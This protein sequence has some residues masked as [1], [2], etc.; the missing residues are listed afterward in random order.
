L[1]DY[2]ARFYDPQIGRWMTIDPKAEQY[3]RWSPYNYC[4]DNPIRFID[5]D[6]MGVDQD[7]AQYSYMAENPLGVVLDGFRQ[8]FQAVASLFSFDASVSTT[9]TQTTTNT[10]SGGT[11]ASNSTISE[12]SATLSFMPQNMF[13]YTGNN[14]AVPSPIVT[15]TSQTVKTEQKVSTTV[16]VEGVPVNLAVSKSQDNNGNVE[17][18][19]EVS[20]GLTNKNSTMEA[21]AYIQVN[22]TTNSSGNTTTTAKAGAEVTVPVSTN[23]ATSGNTKTT[24]TTAVTGKIEKTLYSQ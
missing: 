23:T 10:S 8:Y 17:K 18:T 3:R 22:N 12:S 6:G 14:D 5:P 9:Q 13:N 7:L 24:T 21:N 1:Y 2:G 20:V 16:P 11:T 19:A 4:V 15:S